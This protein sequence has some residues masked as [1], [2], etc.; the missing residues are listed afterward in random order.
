MNKTKKVKIPRLDED[1]VLICKV[2]SEERPAGEEDIKAIQLLLAQAS[3]DG[4]LTFVTH[5]AIKFETI[6][7]KALKN[8]FVGA[9]A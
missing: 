3:V 1:V 2:G 7:K 5:H 4:S 8:I 9:G 6:P